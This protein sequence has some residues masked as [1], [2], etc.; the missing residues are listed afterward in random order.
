M[1]NLDMINAACT[2]QVDPRIGAVGAR[3]GERLHRPG[4]V[5]REA[6]HAAVINVPHEVGGP[7]SPLRIPCQRARQ[8]VR[9]APIAIGSVLP[10]QDS[11]PQRVKSELSTPLLNTEQ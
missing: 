5:V 11:N 6:D 9:D 2:S 10:I 8:I 1:I 7:T 4:G 3:R